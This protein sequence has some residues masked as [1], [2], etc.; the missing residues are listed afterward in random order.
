[1][2]FKYILQDIQ[3]VVKSQAHNTLLEFEKRAKEVIVAMAE[4]GL[5]TALF[6]EN[7]GRLCDFFGKH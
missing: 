1:M 4:Q 7:P 2:V 5:N 3:D 6:Y